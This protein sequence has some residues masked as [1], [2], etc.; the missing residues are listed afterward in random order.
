MLH[1]PANQDTGPDHA[2][3]YKSS[4]GVKMFIIYALIYAGFVVINVID[5]NIMKVKVVLGMNLAVFYG[6]FLIIFALLL[7]LFYNML[8]SKKEAELN[9]S[10]KS[11]GASK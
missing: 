10:N 6:F 3:D 7:A 2:A 8:C 5:P 4:L 1:E 11:E 9:S